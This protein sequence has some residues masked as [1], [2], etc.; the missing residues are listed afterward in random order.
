M[1][2]RTKIILI[3]LF[4]SATLTITAGLLFYH[5]GVSNIRTEIKNHLL[6]AATNKAKWIHSYLLERKQDVEILTKMD[7]VET[8][9]D[10][11]KSYHDAGGASPTGPYDINTE[12]YNRIFSE[13]DPFFKKFLSIYGYYDIFF[14]C[15]DHGHVMYT[16]AKEAGLGTNLITGLYKNSGL[17]KLWKKAVESK[18][19]SLID[20]EYYGTGNEPALFVG[21]PVFDKKGRIYAVV[22]LR[23]DTKQINEIMQDATG[24][25]ETGQTYLVGNDYLMRSDTKA[26]E[27]KTILKQRVDTENARA[28]F[29]HRPDAGA[30]HRD[31]DISKDYRGIKVL[32][33]HIYLPEMDWAL[34]AEIETKEAFA[35]INK[36]KYIMVINAG[37]ILFFIAIVALFVAKTISDP[38]NSLY[39]GVNIIGSGNLD[40]K[41]GTKANDE[42]GQLSRA[43]DEMSGNLKKITVSRDSLGRQVAERTKELEEKIEELE[44]F[45]D[46]TVDRELR[47][48]E[49]RNGIEELE[50]KLK[51]ERERHGRRD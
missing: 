30:R 51:E 15:R 37:L 44:R 2:I 46:A 28:G 35:A 8:A 1:K 23:L 49:L 48:K 12:E 25:G 45:H 14:I 22:A 24:L 32:G 33:T 9:F 40:Y 39:K 20:F 3:F 21:A 13:I 19:L 27:Q 50:K 36:L 18:K 26:S 10:K 11:L 6:T 42:I 47:M 29:L 34:L 38:I 4:T 31:V 16:S 41:V 7:D 17:A 5:F 43:F